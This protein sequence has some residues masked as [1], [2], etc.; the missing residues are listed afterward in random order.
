LYD[1]TSGEAVCRDCGL[2][3]LE[4]VEFTA[5]A[6]RITKNTSSNPLAYTSVAVGTKIAPYQ[7]LELN[8][9][10]EIERVIQQLYLPTATKSIAITYVQHIR[11]S[12]RQQKEPKIRFTRTELIALSIWTALK[13][14]KHPINCNEFSQKIMP[15]IGEVNLMKT[16]K[17]ALHFVENT[18]RISDTTLVTAH[19][20]KIVKTLANNAVIDNHYSHIIGKYAIEMIHTKQNLVKGRKS[21]LI[22]ASAVFAADGLIAEHFTLRVFAEFANVGAGN[23]SSFAEIFKRFAPP[24]PKESAAIHFIENLFKG[25]F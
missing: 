3:I 10:Y 15:L 24:V 20:N 16:E 4:I 18:P 17:R 11:R 21:D 19:I 7:R 22:A 2:V 25:I 5:P 14:L 23:L 1:E 6:D 12:M 8:V 13:Q 9:A